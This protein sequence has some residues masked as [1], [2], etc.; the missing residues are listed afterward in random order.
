MTQIRRLWWRGRRDDDLR[1]LA[2][3]KAELE[4]VQH[5][6]P[7]IHDVVATL[8]RHHQRNHIS[9]NLNAIF[10]GGNP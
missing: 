10:R 6:W 7:V 9:E 8:T 5:Q 3:T 4:R 2:E 1:K